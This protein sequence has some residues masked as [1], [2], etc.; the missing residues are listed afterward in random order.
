VAGVP[1][2]PPPTAPGAGDLAADLVPGPRPG[3]DGEPE[4]D[5]VGADPVGAEAVRADVA[6]GGRA[7]ATRARESGPSPVG[8]EVAAA[9]LEPTP[10][11]AHAARRRRQVWACALV[12]A[13]PALVLALASVGSDWVP[14]GDYGP[15][16]VRVRDVFS[17]HPPILGAFSRLGA[18]HPGPAVFYAL[19]VPYRLLGSEPWALVTGA[20][21]LNA[22]GI[23]LAVRIAGRRG[24]VGSAA[25]LAGLV[26]ACMWGLDIDVLRDPWNPHLALV[27]FLVAVVATWAVGV[28][29]RRSLP[30]AVAATSFCAQ[31]HVG[32]TLLAA[33]LAAWWVVALVRERRDLQ[34]WRSA[35]V[36]SAGVLGLMWALP[37]AQQL[38]G[39]EGNLA[40]IVTR[41]GTEEG[42]ARYG[43]QGVH[44]FVLPH[45]GPTPAWHRWSPADPFELGGRSGLPWPP[46]GLVAAGAGWVVA[47]RRR[48]RDALR[49]LA[50]TASLWVAGAVS[51]S[52]LNGLPA[53]Y[54]YRWV[55]VLGVVL[56]WA[57]L[58]PLG[59]AL[60]ATARPRVAALVPGPARPAVRRGAAGAAA[61]LL[62]GTAIV[63][64]ARGDVA[65][66]AAWR[67]RDAGAGVLADEVQE[68]VDAHPGPADVVQVTWSGPLTWAV[69][70][71]IAEL[72]RH[73]T[74]VLVDP[75]G[76]PGWGAARVPGQ[77]RPDLTVAMGIEARGRP[78]GGRQVAV[79]PDV[80]PGGEQAIAWL[81]PGS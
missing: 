23:A 3:G 19:A 6:T 32:Y 76:G 15:L 20:A 69:P 13:A 62:A 25:L 34:A 33:V 22:A 21:L 4:P 47:R 53:Q 64:A 9:T 63:V 51:I 55:R 2:A 79:V 70:V 50:L 27:P 71:V 30:V 26:L 7:G 67:D 72:E 65:P 73:G 29:S 5:P 60:L 44:D 61:V 37:V 46:L 14:I 39:D 12:A 24:R 81:V 41:A 28:G 59:R 16:E 74:H 52:R 31:A 35:L 80:G 78:P 77:A 36:A 75:G 18:N 42:E 40:R 10:E 38:V 54:L 49:L 45:L 58:W 11:G 57:A 17:T 56:W 1:A 8:A 66:F 43:W 48:D 68:A